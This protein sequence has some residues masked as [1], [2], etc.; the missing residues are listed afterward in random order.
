[1]ISAKLAD[2]HRTLSPFALDLGPALA[3]VQESTY[4]STEL[5]RRTR[6]PTGSAANEAGADTQSDGANYLALERVARQL[7]TDYIAA[8][9]S[10][11]KAA[12][13]GAFRGRS[14]APSRTA[15]NSAEL[16]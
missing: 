13:L 10:R 8:L 4:S 6:Q 2:A 14:A 16:I 5:L 9:M 3:A 15:G 11:C 1:M 7:R 12:I